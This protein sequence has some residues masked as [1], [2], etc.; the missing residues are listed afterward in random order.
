MTNTPYQFEITPRAEADVTKIFDWLSTRSVQ[1][2]KNWFVAYEE[3]LYK[4]LS[5]P[6]HYGLAI[7]AA[8]LS[9]E[10][11]E[12]YFHTQ[13]GKKYRIVFL[14]REQLIVVLCVRRPGEDLLRKS[15][16]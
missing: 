3:A 9:Q 15:D 1:G 12:C 7:E 5:N 14:I 8:R 2:A 16:I 11:R 13:F 10:I 4:I 6:L